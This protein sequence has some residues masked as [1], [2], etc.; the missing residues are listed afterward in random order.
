MNFLMHI[1]GH[2]MF[3]FTVRTY[4]DLLK[5]ITSN[6]YISRTFEKSISSENLLD[7]SVVLRHDVDRIPQNALKLAQIDKTLGISGTYYFRV[8]PES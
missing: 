7:K 1:L 6:K 3:D 2:R 5:T 4:T 8:V